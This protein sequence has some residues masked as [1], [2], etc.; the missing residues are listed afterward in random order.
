[1]YDTV[2]AMIYPV[3]CL[4]CTLLYLYPVEYRL[5]AVKTIVLLELTCFF[6][7]ATLFKDAFDRKTERYERLT[8]D[9]KKLGYAT[10][11]TP[12]EIGARGVITARNHSVLAMVAR[13]CHIQDLKKLRKTLGKIALVASHRIYLARNSND[14]CSG[15]LVSPYYCCPLFL[16]TLV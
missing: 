9:C 15:K 11:N 12:L 5:P 6:D 13:M 3:E 10:Y 14:W 7:S 2:A 8:L 16:L 4:K 1:M